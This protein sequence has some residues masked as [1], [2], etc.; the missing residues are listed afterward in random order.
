MKFQIYHRNQKINGEILFDLVKKDHVGIFETFRVYN[1]NIFHFDEH[2]CRLL[3]SAKTSGYRWKIEPKIIQQALSF[4]IRDSGKQEAIIRL[5]LICGEIFV[6]VG[7]RKYPAA[8][9]KR[10]MVL[11]T[12]P[13]KRSLSHAAPPEA[14]TADYQNAVMAS[15]EPKTGGAEEWLFLN[16]NGYVT[17]V[18]TGNLFMIPPD[19][20]PVLWTPPLQGILNGVTRRFVIECASYL[21]IKTR[22]QW[23]TRHDLYN[24]SEV[25]L[26]NTSWEILPVRELDGRE[27]GV[28]IPGPIT[29]KLHRQF[30]KRVKEE[31]PTS[32]SVAR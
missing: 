10:G 32:L 19:S 30:K 22:E 18:R 16:R 23:F 27:I 7:E 28:K 4:A 15:L 3:E 29:L 21:G 24:A 20:K 13:V 14:K 8:L 17:E 1:G 5:T 9:Y 2:F 11:R 25:F 12:S 31:C 6:M 26:T